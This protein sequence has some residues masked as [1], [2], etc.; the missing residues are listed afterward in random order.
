MR[1]IPLAFL[2]VGML[3][4]LAAGGAVLG[5]VFAPTPTELA[6]HNGAGETLDAAHIIG[7]YT[8]SNLGGDTVN[9]N[10]RAPDHATF[11]AKT[12]TGTVVKRAHVHGSAATGVL[13]PVRALLSLKRFTQHGSVYRNVR[14]VADLVSPSQRSKVSGSY[15]VAVHMAGGYVVQVDVRLDAT[16]QGKQVTQTLDYRLTRVDSWSGG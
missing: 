9:F 1:R 12:A 13:D 10:F 5:A 3:T 15:Q 2:L 11:V 7:V 16:D 14:P 8:S 4:V 6:V